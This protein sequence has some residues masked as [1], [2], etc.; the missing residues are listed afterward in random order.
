MFEISL[1][2]LLI[3]YGVL[4]LIFFVFAAINIYHLMA[5][6]FFSFESIFMTFFLIAGTIVILGITFV[7]GLDINWSFTF[8]I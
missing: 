8:V 3:A 6:G 2:T 7:L 5:F 1:L 4:V